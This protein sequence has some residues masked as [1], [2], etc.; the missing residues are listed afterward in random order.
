MLALHDFLDWHVVEK[1]CHVADDLVFER[2]RIA[3]LVANTAAAA[4]LVMVL[5]FIDSPIFPAAALVK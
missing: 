2:A 3:Q 1:G 4:G 5:R